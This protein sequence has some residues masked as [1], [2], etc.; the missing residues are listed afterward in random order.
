MSASMND[1]QRLRAKL[2][3]AYVLI[4]QARYCYQLPDDV[5]L[6]ASEAC[7]ALGKALDAIERHPAD[8]IR[9]ES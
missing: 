9:R 6:S 3:D 2:V 7:A 4:S 5:R 1:K 8:A